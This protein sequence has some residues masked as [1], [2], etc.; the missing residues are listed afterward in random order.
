[1]VTSIQ[2]YNSVGK[3][4][5]ESFPNLKTPQIDIGHLPRAIYYVEV[6]SEEKRKIIKVI[7]K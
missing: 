7:K 1:L 3:L 2:V 5:L 4:V 6:L